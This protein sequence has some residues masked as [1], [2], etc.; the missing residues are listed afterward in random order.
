MMV[1]RLRASGVATADVG[2]EPIYG[3]FSFTEGAPVLVAEDQRELAR[4]I[5]RLGEED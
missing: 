4:R 5:L 1:N 3:S 2:A